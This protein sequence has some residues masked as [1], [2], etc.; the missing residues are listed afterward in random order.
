[1]TR[2]TFDDD[3]AIAALTASFRGLAL[4]KEQWTHGAHWAAALWIVARCPDVAPER[5]MPDMIRRYNESVGGLNSDS[6]GY[7]ETITLASLRAVRAHLANAQADAPLHAV[8][9][10]LIAGPLGQSDWPLAYWSHERLFSPAARR[11]WVEPDIT[12]LPW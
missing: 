12:P 6:A 9:A 4:P 1:M 11:A 3:E 7:H 2:Q 8:H 10:A 5:D